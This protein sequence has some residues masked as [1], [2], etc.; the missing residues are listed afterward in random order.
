MPHRHSATTRVA[1]VGA[2]YWGANL[3]RVFAELGALAVVCEADS[4][5]LKSLAHT[6][7]SVTLTPKFLDVL[8]DAA[9]SGVVIA[10]PAA[11][12]YRLAREALL[13]GKDVFVEKPLALTAGEGEE[14]VRLA[15]A[16]Q[17]ILM[18]GHLLEYHPA[19]VKLKALVDKGTL[20][21]IEYVYSHRLNFGKVRTEEN[22]L[23]SFAP[24]D[25]SVI[26][27]LLD[28]MP[29]EVS[30]HG[31]TYLREGVADVTVTN[32]TFAS[33]VRAHIFVSWLH[34]YKEQRLVVVGDRKMAVF[35]DMAQ[36][37]LLLYSHHIDWV[38]RMPVPKRENAEAVPVDAT[39]PLQLECRHFL[40]CL[41]ARTVPRTHGES[42]LQ[43]LE[44][45]QACQ[46]SLERNGQPVRMAGAPE[47]VG[48]FVDP[49]AVV[50]EPC[51]IGEGTKIWHF[52]HVMPR[53]A[54]GR[55]C[56]IGQNVFIGSGVAVGDRVK[57]QNNVSVYTG[58]TLEDEVFCGP[59]VVFTNVINP[60]SAVSRKD[61][62]K[63]TLVKRGATLGA[64][65]TILCGHTIG[66]H[67]LVGA[68]AVVTHDVPDYGVVYGNP[69]RLKGWVCSCGVSLKFRGTAA[70]CR[71][72]GQAYRK[73]QQG[74]IP[75]ATRQ[76]HAR[77][78]R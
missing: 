12:H 67:A 7:P 24:H 11:T 71:V 61:E 36:D 38:D 69:A 72:C 9:I 58:V 2:G 59:S 51:Q 57:I 29:T 65:S 45:L 37:K 21:K 77:A 10:T 13:A 25:L 41:A 47:R 6:Y 15:H 39:E 23:W 30:A 74:V 62:F 48:A 66:R 28:E 27:L 64:N 44:I 63:P 43:V 18:V 75:A 4:G 60:R 55:H 3:V 34:P 76:P 70:K 33:G 78:S 32:L 54:I 49:T 5:R 22:I 35:N 19:V 46:A 53:A 1:V 20:G 42:A 26:R 50:E 31:A 73:R 68:G 8:S 56:V 17:R 14:L 52:A 16:Q 40:E